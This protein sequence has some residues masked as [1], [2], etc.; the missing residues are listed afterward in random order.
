MFPKPSSFSP[1]C[2]PQAMITTRKGNKRFA[3]YDLKMTL[4][5]TA[6]PD[7]PPAAAAAEGAE[8][9]EAAALT[10]AEAAVDALANASLGRGG[11]GEGE[12]EQPPEEGAPEGE[13]GGASLEAAEPAAVAA[14]AAAAPAAPTSSAPAISGEIVVS[15]FGSG[16]DHDDIE[17]TVTVT[18][19]CCLAGWLAGLPFCSGRLLFCVFH[20]CHGYSLRVGGWLRPPTLA[21][22]AILPGSGGTSEE[23]ATLRRHVQ[24]TLW[25]LVLQLL[26]QYV[27]ELGEQ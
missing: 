7:A 18:G 5:W 16:S 9:G 24:V 15:E 14:T 3:F 11:S 13:A 27:R 19:G 6:A 2:T 23:Q 21:P 10:P 26:E 4:A 25:P 17:L 20:S 22:I 8:G 1:C 12:A